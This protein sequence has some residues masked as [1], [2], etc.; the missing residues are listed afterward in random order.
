[1]DEGRTTSIAKDDALTVGK[2]L[3][4]TAADSVTIV[5]G[6]A[7]IALKKDG[8]VVIKGKEITFDG[9]KINL[10]ASGDITLKGSKVKQN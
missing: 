9:T 7:S 2:S 8:T 6:S 4:I 10:K 1:M 5:A 3:K